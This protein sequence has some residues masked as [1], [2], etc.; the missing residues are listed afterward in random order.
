[1]FTFK[2]YLKSKISNL[3]L[4]KSNSR[5][6]IFPPASSSLPLTD[7]LEW[8][9]EIIFRPTLVTNAS[10]DMVLTISTAPLKKQTN[11]STNMVLTIS[12]APLK[13]QT[14]TSTDMVLTISTAPLKKQTNTSTNMVL[15][16][17][18]TPLK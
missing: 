7:E 14:N 8:S 3:S 11:T 18:T 9:V 4:G 2:S 5:L 6:K 16:I 13:K 17:S 15:T 12:T 1:M 10:T